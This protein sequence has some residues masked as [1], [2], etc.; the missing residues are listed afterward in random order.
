MKDLNSIYIHLLSIGL[1]HARELLSEGRVLEAKLEM[2]HLYAIPQLLGSASPYQHKFYLNDL[3]S[4]F[5][6]DARTMGAERL[7]QHI[8]KQYVP[9]WEDL[10]A[11]VAQRFDHAVE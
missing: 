11:A 5:I 10:E 8:D 1:I 9:I 4:R 6:E 3:R 2:D 7:V